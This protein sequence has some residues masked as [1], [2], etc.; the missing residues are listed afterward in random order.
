M[1]SRNVYTL[2]FSNR[3]WEVTLEI[4]RRYGIA[5]L[6]DIRT[7]PGSRHAPQF[8]QE[9][10]VAA[11]PAV[12]VEY[13]HLKSLGGL[14]KPKPGDPTNAAWRNAGF[15]AYA[16]YMQTAAFATAL[17]ELV[18][19]LLAKPTAFACTEA[20]FWRCH[21]ALVSDA[22]LIRGYLPR[23]IFSVDRCDPHQ[24]TSFASV[25]GRRITYPEPRLFPE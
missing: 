9:H 18:R 8:N 1:E 7:L 20:V 19:L 2:G 24:I 23:H 21:R 6:I 10:L 16:D 15:R 25:D 4:L 14:R 11:L 5:R 3:T 22:L 13:I 17:D 12:G